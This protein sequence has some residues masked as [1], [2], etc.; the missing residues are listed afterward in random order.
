MWNFVKGLFKRNK[1]QEIV[2]EQPKAILVLHTI[3]PVEIPPCFLKPKT[4]VEPRIVEKIGMHEWLRS[5]R[6]VDALRRRL[7]MAA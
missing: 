4:Q 6:E 7:S 1:K 3:G 5:C 2:A